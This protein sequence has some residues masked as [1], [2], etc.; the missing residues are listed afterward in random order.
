M[1]SD[2]DRAWPSP[3]RAPGA[4]RV[5]SV[6]IRPAPARASSTGGAARF[7]FLRAFQTERIRQ[8]GA[9][10]EHDEALD[11]QRQVARQLGLED[12]RVEVALRRP[13]RAARRRAAPRGPTPIA[14]L[15]P[16]RATAM[17]RKPIVDS[18]IVLAATRY[19]QPRTSMA[20]PMPAKR[21]G[22]RHGEEVAP[23]HADAAVARR[24][25][26]V[27]DRAHL[28]AERRP[29]E[30]DRID[31][32]R[33]DPEEDADV[34]ALEDA[35]APERRELAGR[36]PR[37]PDVDVAHVV[38][39]S[40][41]SGPEQPLPGPEHDPVEHDR[42]DH[43]VGADRRLQEPGDPGE[44]RTR[45]RGG[46][47]WRGRRAGTCVM[48]GERRADPDG[49]ERAGDVL[50]LAADVEEP[51]AERERDGEP[52]EDQRRRQQQGLLEGIGV[53]RLEAVRV[54]AGTRP[55]VSVNGHADV[56]AARVEEPAQ[57]RPVEDRLV[58]GERVVA[59]R[60]RATTRPPMR[61]ASSVVTSGT[62]S[63]AGP[64]EDVEALGDA[65]RVAAGLLLRRLA[66][67]SRRRPAGRPRSRGGLLLAAAADHRDPERLGVDARARTRRRSAPR[68]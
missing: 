19:S 35:E 31:D 49:G 55:G 36:R 4:R 50:A 43:L 8:V 12:R 52:G 62:T 9:D 10:E 14:V 15:R 18:E 13:G 6:L 23:R 25:R 66:P 67:A 53:A 58:R 59:G 61:N 41:P 3:R 42:H 1:P 56:V 38:R 60:R 46:A 68:T 11:D 44:Q 57:A 63:A 64:L 29:V 26:A 39:S 51:A 21:P 47:R 27:A 17:P 22:D 5:A 24:V 48:L 16:S 32:E 54:P 30:D 37:P 34:G 45:E 7:S 28:V 40:G 20:P 33:G 2:A 65:R